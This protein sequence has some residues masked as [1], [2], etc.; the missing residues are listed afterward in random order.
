MN[1]T[2]NNV[3]TDEGRKCYDFMVDRYGLRNDPSLYQ[4]LIDTLQVIGDDLSE[5]VDMDYIDVFESGK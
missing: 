4:N 5:V 1:A 3:L 2:D